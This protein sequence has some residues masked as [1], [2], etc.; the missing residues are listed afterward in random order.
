MPAPSAAPGATKPSS[1]PTSPFYS[2]PTTTQKL[3][4]QLRQ[5]AP[6]VT[7]SYV[8]F[9]ATQKL[10]GECARQADY[11][12]PSAGQ[13]TTPH[14]NNNN[15][16]TNPN[17][18]PNAAGI[19]IGVGDS[20]SWWYQELRLPP[21]FNTWAQVTML[22]MYLFAARFR[23]L[24]RDP[25]AAWQQQLLDHFFFDA[26]RRMVE[27]HGLATRM[28]RA[29]HLKDLFVLYR[30]AL[31][32]YDE[33]LC[34]GDAVLA[35]ALWRNVLA[36]DPDADLVGL[37]MVTA[38]VR[39]TLQALEMIPDEDLAVGKVRFAHPQRNAEEVA[40]RSRALNRA[41]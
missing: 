3:A 16:N 20:D 24:G 23:Q 10:Y 12:M 7:E 6:G 36:A 25:C 39:R 18:S 9:S 15:N 8:A 2:P 35:A 40:A 28:A 4:A 21:T 11:T 26:E 29:R 30:G 27:K 14:N 37:A 5:H 19:D 31:A 1:A 33:G 38:H 34:R 41:V 13:P 22:H 17:P 32:A